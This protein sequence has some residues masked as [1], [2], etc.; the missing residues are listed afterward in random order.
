M[1]PRRPVKV[2]QLEE[3]NWFPARGLRVVPGKEGERLIDGGRDALC[4][5]HDHLAMNG[6]DAHLGLAFRR[7]H[8]LIAWLDKHSPKA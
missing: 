2:C 6:P 3:G 8:R 4:R 1:T 7:L 5:L